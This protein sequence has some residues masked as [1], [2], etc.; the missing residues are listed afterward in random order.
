[1]GHLDTKAWQQPSNEDII[2]AVMVKERKR[3]E[4][5]SKESRLSVKGCNQEARVKE[6][7]EKESKELTSSLP[8]SDER[9]CSTVHRLCTFT[10]QFK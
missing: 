6:K 8:N 2:R 1:M 9:G 10:T 7:R 3:E 4:L 5:C